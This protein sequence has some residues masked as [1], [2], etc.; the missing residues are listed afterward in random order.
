M[1]RR[2]FAALCKQW[3]EVEWKMTSPRLDFHEYCCDDQPMPWVTEIMVGDLQR[4]MEYPKLGFQVA[5]DIP[6]NVERAYQ[7]LIQAGFDGH[8]MPV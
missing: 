7:F 6:P 2:A 5:Q 1:E 8:L 3:P 4:I